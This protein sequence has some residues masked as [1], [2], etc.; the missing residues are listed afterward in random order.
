MHYESFDG[1]DNVVEDARFHVAETF[2]VVREAALRRIARHWRGLCVDGSPPARADLDPVGFA[3]ALPRIYIADRVEGPPF[4][5]YRVAGGEIESAFRRG[6]LKGVGLDEIL[7]PDGFVRVAH[8]WSALHERGAAIY[9]HGLIYKTAHR[10]P[11]GG[12]LLLPLCDGRDGRVT[13]LFGM[14]DYTLRDQPRDAY[15]GTL[16]IHV[17]DDPVAHLAAD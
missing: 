13:G 14:T 16:D 6:S 3:W 4:W 12:R 2:D 1:G 10:Y 8:R 17:I 5:R 15:F 7:P 9:M 11:I